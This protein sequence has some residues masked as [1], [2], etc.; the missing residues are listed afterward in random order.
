LFEGCEESVPDS[1]GPWSGGCH[2]GFLHDDLRLYE[3]ISLQK[4]ICSGGAVSIWM[5]SV[6]AGELD[7][8]KSEHL[9]RI[10]AIGFGPS[11]CGDGSGGSFRRI[12]LHST[13]YSQ[14]NN[15]AI[16]R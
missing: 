6:K 2:R 4:S 11:I 3:G 14:L 9:C 12:I 7:A 5:D 13:E 15:I 16:I 10:R 1:A 8:V